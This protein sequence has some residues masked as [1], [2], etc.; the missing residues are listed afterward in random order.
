[1]PGRRQPVSKQPQSDSNHSQ[2]IST[3]SQDRLK[4]QLDPIRLQIDCRFIVT[5]MQQSQGRCR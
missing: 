2:T 5:L 3:L 1:M 4:L